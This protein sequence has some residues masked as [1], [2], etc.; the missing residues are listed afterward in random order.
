MCSEIVLGTIVTPAPEATI[1]RIK[2]LNETSVLIL[3]FTFHFSYSQLSL[4]VYHIQ[5]DTLLA[6]QAIIDS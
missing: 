6:V 5:Q 3:G 1:P 2:S 4:C